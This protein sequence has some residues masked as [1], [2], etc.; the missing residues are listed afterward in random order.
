M[1]TRITAMIAKPRREAGKATLAAREVLKMTM[2]LV[3]VRFR[4]GVGVREGGG[5]GLGGGGAARTWGT[6]SFTRTACIT[7]GRS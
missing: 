6:V 7:K 2:L 5:G 1:L 4:Y 3:V